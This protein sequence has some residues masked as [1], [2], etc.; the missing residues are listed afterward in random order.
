MPPFIRAC[1]LAGLAALAAPASGTS[2]QVQEETPTD[3]PA[4]KGEEVVSKVS[5]LTTILY[6]RP[7]GSLVKKG[8]LVCELDAAP[9]RQRLDEQ[10]AATIVAK[11]AYDNARLPRESAEI[12]LKEYVEGIFKQEWESLLGRIS[13]AESA[14]KQAQQRLETT[15]RLVD[16]N[17]LPRDRLVGDS[18]ALQRATFTLNQLQ[19]KKSILEK[20]TRDKMTK[21]FQSDIE[22]ARSNELAKQSAYSLAQGARDR[23]QK[24]IEG[25]RVLAPINGRLSYSPPIEEAAEVQEGQLLFRVVAEDEPKPGEK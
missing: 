25:C 18:I 11:A 13:L 2:A 16:Q 9:L 19:T 5:G 22:K 24:Q 20:Y 1:F 7:A 15:K 21:K 6:L 10:E 3:I 23:T 12:A 14:Q 17:K 4:R 8:D